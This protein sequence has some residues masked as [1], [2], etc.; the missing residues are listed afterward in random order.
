MRK[1]SVP[2]QLLSSFWLAIGPPDPHDVVVLL[3]VIEDFTFST[4]RLPDSLLD[5]KMGQNDLQND[6]GR[7]SKSDLKIIDFPGRLRV[8]DYTTRPYP[9]VDQNGPMGRL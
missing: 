5:A 4:F 9:M 8:R 6:F 2:E 1:K 7:L 3:G